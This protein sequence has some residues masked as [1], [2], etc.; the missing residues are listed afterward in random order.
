MK[1][2]V[3]YIHRRIRNPYS[4]FPLNLTHENRKDF[5]YILCGGIMGLGI[6]YFNFKNYNLIWFMDL[7]K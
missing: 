3:N 6:N 7:I 1:Y 4:P 5:D 2:N